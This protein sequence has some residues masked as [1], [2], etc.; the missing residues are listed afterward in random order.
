MR[1]LDSLTKAARGVRPADVST[2]TTVAIGEDIDYRDEQWNPYVAISDDSGIDED[3]SDYIRKKSREGTPPYFI[4]RASSFGD[5][6]YFYCFARVW[7]F[8][9]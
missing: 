9:W 1:Q 4:R 3:V 8:G 5:T 6:C 2:E 7:G